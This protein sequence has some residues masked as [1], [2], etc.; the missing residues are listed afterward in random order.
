[1]ALT[2]K[3]KIT[4]VEYDSM[5]NWIYYRLHVDKNVIEHPPNIIL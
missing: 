4:Q 5:N 1:M 2:S 3:L